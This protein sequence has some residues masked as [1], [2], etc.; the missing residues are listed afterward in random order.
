MGESP[1]FIY[2][3]RFES[4]S[5]KEKYCKIIARHNIG[6]NTCPYCCLLSSK[7]KTLLTIII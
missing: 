3:V 6:Q 1:A 4:M 5:L 7:G 2:H